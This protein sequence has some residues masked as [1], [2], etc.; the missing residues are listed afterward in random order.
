MQGQQGVHPRLAARRQGRSRSQAGFTLLEVLLSMTIGLILLAPVGGWMIMAMEQQGPT[1]SRF[2]EA[3]QARIANTYLSRDVGSAELVRTAGDPDLATCDGTDPTEVEL[4]LVNVRDEPLRTVYASVD[5]GGTVSVHRRTCLV[6]DKAI[7]DDT[8]VLRDVGATAGA[9]CAPTGLT[10]CSQVTFTATLPGGALIDVRAMRRATLDPSK[11]GTGGN[12][13]PFATVEELLKEGSRPTFTWR[14]RST[15]ADIDGTL[16]PPVWS[17]S[18]SAGVSFTT[19]D[20]G[21]EATFLFANPGLHKVT[22]TVTDDDGDSASTSIELEVP[23]MSPVVTAGIVG[24]G[25][26]EGNVGDGTPGTGD[27]F[28]FEASYTDDGAPDAIASWTWDFGSDVDVAN[29]T[30][31]DTATPTV[32]FL[33]SAIPDGKPSEVRDVRV[34]AQDVYGATGT[35]RVTIRLLNPAAPPP[36]TGSIVVTTDSEV[37]FNQLVNVPGKLPRAG[38]VG[39]GRSVTV[40]FTTASAGTLAWELRK[41]ATVVATNAGNSWAHTF[42]DGDAGPWTIALTVDGG[43]ETPLEFRLNA[44]PVAN[45]SAGSGD[46]THAVQ[47]SDLSTDDGVVEKWE[48]DFDFFAQPGW[49][50]TQKNPSKLFGYPGAYVVTLI[51]TDDDGAKSVVAVDGNLIGLTQK[52]ATI[53]GTVN[54]PAAGSFAGNTYSWAPI[55]GADAYEV[56]LVVSPGG[57][58]STS[59]PFDIKGLVPVLE[60][61]VNVAYAGCQVVATHRVLVAGSWSHYSPQVTR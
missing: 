17:V 19:N 25:S 16:A 54:N 41:G 29:S 35:Q 45:F 38:T 57:G 26:P 61:S 58:C 56:H 60:P 9:T 40:T 44:A 2:T 37:P 53:P 39:P 6:S 11:I 55:P 13:I 32:R 10:S 1:S 31:L 47:F 34:T 28:A 36:P 49:T 4:E 50:S 42:T 8:K 51:V 21:D 3:A 30:G 12:T 15:S 23:N 5:D 14:L 22:L 7:I 52:T 20:D 43:T 24:G 48:W 18:P 59:G 33:A 46:T 27:P